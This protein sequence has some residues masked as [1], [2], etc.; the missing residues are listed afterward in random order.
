[1]ILST[2]AA[3]SQTTPQEVPL[4]ERKFLALVVQSTLP[5]SAIDEL[6]VDSE[7]PLPG[8]ALYAKR[9]IFRDGGSLVIDGLSSRQDAPVL[10]VAQEIEIA[11]DTRRPLLIVRWPGV[12]EGKAGPPGVPGE[13]R[14]SREGQPGGS[15]GPGQPGIAGES[16]RNGPSVILLVNSIK[17][18]FVVNL[19]GQPGGKGGRG[20]DGGRGGA[21]GYGNPASQSAFDC[22][23]GP[24]DGGRGGQGGAA[25]PGGPG[26]SAGSGGFLTVILPNP[27]SLPEVVMLQAEPGERGPG[28][29]AGSPG[30]GGPGGRVGQ[31]ALPWCRQ[32]ASNGVP[33]SG[34]PKASPGS[35]GDPGTSGSI[36]FLRSSEF[37]YLVPW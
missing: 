28:G 37:G 30:P 22:R 5:R 1:M 24:G 27:A 18:Q 36:R 7:L 33:G 4:T 2:S 13:D 12:I 35:S 34:G 26:G 6:V 16:G 3:R 31:E 23:R 11:T 14:G 25:G 10:I 15:G 19:R 20:G 32:T 8:Q 17:G 21:G 29:E 9:L